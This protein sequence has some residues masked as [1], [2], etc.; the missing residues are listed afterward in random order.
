MRAMSIVNT[1]RRIIRYCLSVLSLE[2]ENT[3]EN[4]KYEKKTLEIV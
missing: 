4:W 2:R 1:P 3:I